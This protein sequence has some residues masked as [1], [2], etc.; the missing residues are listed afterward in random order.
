ML[1]FPFNV[2]ITC[3]GLTGDRAGTHAGAGIP[4]VVYVEAAL[5]WCL[6]RQLFS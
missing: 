1:G 5:V 2:H 3:T 6:L 4:V